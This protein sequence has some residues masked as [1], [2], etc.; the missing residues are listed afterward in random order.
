ML[1]Q[2]KYFLMLAILAQARCAETTKEEKL[3]NDITGEGQFK[4]PC[5]VSKCP[6]GKECTI[7]FTPRLLNIPI[8]H[9]VKSNSTAGKGTTRNVHWQD[10]I[11]MPFFRYVCGVH[12]W[13][14]HSTLQIWGRMDPCRHS[15][16]WS[17]KLGNNQH[18]ERGQYT[19]CSW[20][21]SNL[22]IR[23]L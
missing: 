16:V 21:T 3:S 9:C 20:N 1:S 14:Q 8:A 23:T 11:I 17:P 18:A 19:I 10:C 6:I 12:T 13:Y 7:Q 22:S 15:S 2:I 5:K 4:N